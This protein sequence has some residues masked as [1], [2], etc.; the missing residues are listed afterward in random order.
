MESTSFQYP[1]FYKPAMTGQLYLPDLAGAAQAGQLADLPPAAGDKRRVM[2]L[3]ID[4]QIDFVFSDGS[5]SVP[6]AVEDTRRIIEWIFEHTGQITSISASLDSHNTYQIFYPMWWGNARGE[7][8]A[9]FTVITSEDLRQG[10]W[11]PL[12]ETVWSYDYVEKL[13]QG[14]RYALMIWPY[15][16]M[17]GSPGQALVPALSEAIMYHAVARHA[18]PAWLPKGSIP[19]TEYYSILEPEVKIPDHPQGDVNTAFL[20]LLAG[21]DLVYVAGQ[22]KSH[23]VL[24][25]LRSITDQVETAPEL[26]A[27][28][29]VLMDCTSAVQHPQI[30]FDSL[31][32]TELARM[33]ALGVGLVTSTMSIN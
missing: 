20:K 26:A 23:C 27:K 12:I 33:E 16:T 25:T 10:I 19:H 9:P 2:L 6:G 1:A 3:L 11:R 15:H 7:H 28:L 21:Y 17:I 22:A 13:E 24:S 18:Q 29:R 30:D 8:P 5:L 32:N 31:A 14:G 4:A